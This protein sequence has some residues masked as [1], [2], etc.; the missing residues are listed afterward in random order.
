MSVILRLK[1]MGAR[2]KPFYRIVATDSRNPR[3][4]KFLETVGHYDPNKAAGAQADFN[5]ERLDHWLKAGAAVS[6][7]VKSLIKKQ[8][9]AK[10]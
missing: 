9:A 4:G 3:D 8:A 6:D 7:T 1:R 5:K 10:Q 2:K